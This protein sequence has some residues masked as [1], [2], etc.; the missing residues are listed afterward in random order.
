MC[1]SL[2]YFQDIKVNCLAVINDTVGALMSCAHS[3]N[4]CA[5]GLILGKYPVFIFTSLMVQLYTRRQIF[6]LIQ[7]ESICRRQKIDVAEKLKFVLG[8]VENI[9]GKGENAGYQHFL[10]FPQC[11]QKASYTGSLKVVMVW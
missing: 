7:I 10:L 2:T 5:I 8:R 11:F 1:V 9:V 4:Q 6:R 3:D